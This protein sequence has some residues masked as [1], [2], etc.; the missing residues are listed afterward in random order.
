MK[1]EIYQLSNAPKGVRKLHMDPINWI[2]I[3]DNELLCVTE[4]GNPLYS[5]PL[6]GML[7]KT[8]TT[9]EA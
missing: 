7:F 1:A 3:S 2:P 5:N 8:V 6:Y 9:A 4:N